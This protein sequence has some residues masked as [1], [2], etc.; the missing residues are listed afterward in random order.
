ML[1][2]EPFVDVLLELHHLGIRLALDDFGT[3]WSSVSRLTALPW[4]VLKIDQS[5]IAA[6]TDDDDHA[7]HVVASMIAMAHSLGMLTTAEGVETPYQLERLTELD[8][9]IAQGFL[10]SKAVR[11][12]D[13]STHVSSN[14]RWTGPPH[15]HRRQRLASFATQSNEQHLM[16]V[17]VWLRR[18]RPFPCSRQAASSAM[19]VMYSVAGVTLLV[20]TVLPQPPTLNTR[21]LV[22]L[23]VSGCLVAGMVHL[24]RDQLPIAAHQWLIGVGT[25]LNTILV[26]TGGA[27]RNASLPNILG[28]DDERNG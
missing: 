26:A 17:T 6:L 5:F 8:C 1:A 22:I 12:R 25:V 19:T 16:D 20:A 13:A 27:L 2:R 21:V 15:L 28:L 3:R 18:S 4:D 23:G 9:D 10:F 14:M 24:K 11:M 7:E